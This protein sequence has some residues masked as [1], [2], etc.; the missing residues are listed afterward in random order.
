MKDIFQCSASYN[1]NVK[2]YKNMG[3]GKFQDRTAAA[4]L[5]GIT[6]GANCRQADFNNDGHVDIFLMRG[7]WLG[8]DHVNGLLR[9]NG[10]GTFTDIAFYAGISSQG[11]THTMDFGDINKDGLLDMFVA[12]EDLPCELWLNLGNDTV[13]NIA[14]AQILDCGLVKG[15]VFTDYNDDLVRQLY[16]TV[17]VRFD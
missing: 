9:N 11:A 14:D 12:N 16:N 4:N 13:A 1:R 10:N 8:I 15:A 6:G 5:Q 17:H 3:D 2:Y 7:G